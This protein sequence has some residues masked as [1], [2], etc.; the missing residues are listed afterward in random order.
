MTKDHLPSMSL[1][2][3]AVEQQDHAGT[4]RKKTSKESLTTL[5]SLE[6]SDTVEKA[7]HAGTTGKKRSAWWLSLLTPPGP[8]TQIVIAAALAIGTGLAVSFTVDEVPKAAVALIK[9]PGDCWL[10]AL[11]CVG[12]RFTIHIL[13][14]QLD[15]GEFE[16]SNADNPQSCH[17]S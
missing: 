2:T 13:L 4:I 7:D 17:S 1:E 9:L 6:T 3:T 15:S 8:A 14:I 12:T 5:V 10:R 16:H 11:K